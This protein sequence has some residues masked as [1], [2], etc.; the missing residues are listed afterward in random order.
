ME[1]RTERFLNVSLVL[2]SLFCICIFIVQA[3][4]M[5]LMGEDAIRHLGVFYM[6]GMSK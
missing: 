4:C 2:V 5:G 6:S 1:K 3:I